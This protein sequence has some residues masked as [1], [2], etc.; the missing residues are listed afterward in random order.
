MIVVADTSNKRDESPSLDM[1]SLML[2]DKVDKSTDWFPIFKRNCKK[3][4]V[5][6]KNWHSLVTIRGA[7]F[8]VSNLNTIDEIKVYGTRCPV[9]EIKTVCKMGNKTIVD[10]VVA[11][12]PT[13]VHKKQDSWECE[14]SFPVG[15]TPLCYGSKNSTL[16]YL[17]IVF[18][19][20]GVMIVD[21]SPVFYSIIWDIPEKCSVS[22]NSEIVAQN[23]YHKLE[24]LNAEPETISSITVYSETSN[25]FVFVTVQTPKMTEQSMRFFYN[26]RKN[27]NVYDLAGVNPEC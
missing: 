13:C 9:H 22:I 15:F 7:L 1:K 12:D 5:T 24:V 26:S 10:M 17:A 20:L 18:Q 4:L 25:K 21:V 19:E 8:D 6:G 2:P 3:L 27:N 14:I 11:I 23:Q 16:Q